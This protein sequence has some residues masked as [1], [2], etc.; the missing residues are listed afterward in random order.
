MWLHV[1]AEVELCYVA[2]FRMFFVRV[3]CQIVSMCIR[4]K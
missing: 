1:L 2:A 4:Y 3:A